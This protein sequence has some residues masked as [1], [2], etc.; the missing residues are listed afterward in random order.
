[1]LPLDLI[2]YA[3]VP[4]QIVA[5]VQGIEVVL[6]Q[7]PWDFSGVVGAEVEFSA[8]E[9]NADAIVFKVAEATCRSL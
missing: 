2:G 5:Y 6:L 1:M 9:K 7:F 3:N 4:Q 8:E